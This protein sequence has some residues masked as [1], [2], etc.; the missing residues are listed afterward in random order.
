MS[1]DFAD[2]RK[3]W[4]FDFSLSDDGKHTLVLYT[5]IIDLYFNSIQKLQLIGTKE[6]HS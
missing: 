4:R 6:R 5:I 3:V 1:Q 2:A